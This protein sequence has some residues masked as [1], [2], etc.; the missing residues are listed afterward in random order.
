MRRVS[1]S[2]RTIFAAVAIVVALALSGCNAPKAT[3]TP[4][5]PPALA[6]ETPTREPTPNLTQAVAVLPSATPTSLPTVAPTTTPVPT[7]TSTS[8]PEPLPSATPTVDCANEATFVEDITIPDDTLLP[9]GGTFVKTWRLQNSGTCTWDSGYTLVCTD[10]DCMGGPASSPLADVVAPGE[11]TDLSVELVA[12]AAQG[13]HAGNWGLAD[14]GGQV[15]GLGGSPGA[16]FWVRIVVAAPTAPATAPPPGP[17]GYTNTAYGFAFQY[18]PGWVLE[19]SP[20]EV[21]L[22]QGTLELSIAY[23]RDGEEIEIRPSGLPAGEV[24]ERGL[25]DVLGLE[26]PRM[27]LSYQNMVRAVYY[28][29]APAE[30]RARD[31]IFV[32]I[33]TQNDADPAVAISRAEQVE[34]DTLVQ[35]LTLIDTAP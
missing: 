17:P 2:W 11:T 32:I 23:K 24:V 7:P 13:N 33:L 18:P 14:S 1:N 15:F 4:A 16:P 34:V 29:G 8:T 25:V 27:V 22:V 5:E 9:P 12:P 28:G 19:E 30:I 35:S 6:T 21:K 26:I 10:G 3:A 31:R 20:H